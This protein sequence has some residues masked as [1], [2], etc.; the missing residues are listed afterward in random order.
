M[1]LIAI[2]ISPFSKVLF[3][4]SLPSF[5]F[6][7]DL[8][9]SCPIPLFL[10]PPFGIFAAIKFLIGSFR[11]NFNEKFEKYRFFQKKLKRALVIIRCHSG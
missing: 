2:L 11:E 7:D 10:S 1:S 6:A 3:W 9:A 4:Q 5:Y 8:A